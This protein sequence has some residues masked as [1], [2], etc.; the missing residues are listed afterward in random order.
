MGDINGLDF[1]KDMLP[2]FQAIP[3]I[4]YS[5]FVNKEM[6]RNALDLKVSRFI[7]K[8]FDVSRI[9]PS[10]KEEAKDRIELIHEKLTL[11]KIFIEE[12]MDLLEDLESEDSSP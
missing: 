6:L 5:G 10:F 4:I 2:D 8:P 9:K 12:A 3:F 7:D 11:K 1:R